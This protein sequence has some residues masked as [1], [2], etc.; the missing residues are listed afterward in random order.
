MAGQVPAIY[1]MP[2]LIELLF[3]IGDNRSV[4]V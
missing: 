4:S 1:L 3:D 2:N